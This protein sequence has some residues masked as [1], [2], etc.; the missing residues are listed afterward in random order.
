MG[1]NSA[2][3]GR[4]AS[5]AGPAASAM[6]YVQRHH[7]WL[8]RDLRHPAHRRA[9][10]RGPRRPPGRRWRS[11]TRRS[12]ATSSARRPPVGRRVGYGDR[13]RRDRPSSRSSAW[14]T[15]AAYRGVRE[16]R[17][18]RRCTGPRRRSTGH[19]P[20]FINLDRADGA[21]RRARA[22]A[23][24]DARHPRRRSDAH[25]SPIR[26]MAD[27]V[28]DQLTEIRTI[29]LLSGVLRRAGAASSPAIGLYGVTSYGVAERRREIG[30]RLTLGAGRAPRSA[31]CCGASR[32]WSA[33]ASRSARRQRPPHRR[34]CSRCSTSSSRAIRRPS[35]VPP[36][37][38]RDR[39]ARRLAAG[40][41]RGANRSSAGAE[42]GLTRASRQP[43]AARVRMPRRAQRREQQSARSR[44][45]RGRA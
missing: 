18:R 12:P 41:T 30:I 13:P 29:A 9:R 8:V 4:R 14:S 31:W 19:P 38:S 39:P 23:G 21:G 22:A 17:S 37:C 26:T 45:A 5:R 11:S 10:L 24:A 43:A 6:S 27:R 34:C 36:P 35:A 20:P 32:G 7:A 44:A 40:E 42:R 33:S 1:W 2:D 25:R 15:D 3:R 28:R 16:R